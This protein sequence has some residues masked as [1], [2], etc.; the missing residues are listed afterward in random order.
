MTVANLKRIRTA[1]SAKPLPLPASMPTQAAK[2]SPW[3][4][5]LGAR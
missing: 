2:R 4:G 3:S 5:T 1:Q